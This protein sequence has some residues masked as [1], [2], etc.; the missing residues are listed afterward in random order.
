MIRV[1]YLLAIKDV[2]ER[3]RLIC[4]TLRGEKWR[5]RTHKGNW[6]KVN[7]K[8]MVDLAQELQ[9]WTQSVYKFGCAFVHLS[10]F[11]NHFAEN[12]FDKLEEAEKRDILSHM[13]YYHNGPAVEN[14][15]V[16]ELASYVPAVF[17][18]IAD[19]LEC[20]LKQLEQDGSLN[21]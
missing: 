7:D 21:D 19:N 6:K 18:K 13:R 11:H 20:Y 4:S 10:D 5:I 16:S 9:G 12:P 14:P 2:S 8:E 1:I 15:G 3:Q 17:D